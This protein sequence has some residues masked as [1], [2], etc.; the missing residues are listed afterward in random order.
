[1]NLSQQWYENARRRQWQQKKWRGKIMDVLKRQVK[2]A[3]EE[4]T[5][6]PIG[7]LDAIIRPA[8]MGRVL[9]NLAVDVGVR[10]ANTAFLELKAQTKRASL[11]FDKEFAQQII[12]YL[13]KYF[14]IT[15]NNINEYTKELILQVITEGIA[16]GEGQDVIVQNILGL[17]VINS[18]RA[19]TIVRTEVNRASNIGRVIGA[20]KTGLLLKKVW[21][22]A[23]QERTR[24]SKPK[25][26]ADHRHM[27]ALKVD[28]NEPFTDPRNGAKLDQPGDPNAPI[29]NTINCRC[30]VAFEPQ[31][32]IYGNYIRIEKP[33]YE[34]V[35]N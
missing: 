9:Y 23:N 18:R 19:N 11:G 35:F 32:D 7:N 3:A 10:E 14:L 2:A 20:K 22:S 27:N 1:M 30:V 21:S 31:K 28:M 26:K 29:E 13:Q 8:D 6:S 15:V 5:K 17:N 24:G 16:K 33:L 34:S 25:D 12:D 4:F